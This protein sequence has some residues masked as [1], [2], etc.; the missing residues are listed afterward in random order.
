VNEGW[1]AKRYPLTYND[2]VIAGPTTDEA[3]N[4]GT[5]RCASRPPG[6]SLRYAPCLPRGRTIPGP[7]KQWILLNIAEG[8][9]WRLAPVWARPSRRRSQRRG[10]RTH[11]KAAVRLSMLRTN[12]GHCTSGTPSRYNPKMA[13]W[14]G[15]PL[16]ADGT[17]LLD[18]RSDQTLPFISYTDVAAR[19]RSFTAF[20][21]DVRPRIIA[22][23]ERR[24]QADAAYSKAKTNE[25]ARTK[26]TQEV[27]H[28][29]LHSTL[30]ALHEGRREQR[31]ELT[32][33]QTLRR[34]EHDVTVLAASCRRRGFDTTPLP[35][36]SSLCIDIGDLEHRYLHGAQSPSGSRRATTKSKDD[37][38]CRQHGVWWR[39]A[40]FGLVRSPENRG[41]K[42]AR[43]VG[44]IAPGV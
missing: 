26:A 39:G 25:R 6:R 29:L 36:Q 16:R 31:A 37:A 11:P 7:T 32:Q 14:A 28:P 41:R 12:C 4:R 30:V 22:E 1:G 23:G 15:L 17:D 24:A 10:V 40:I 19:A 20:K 38:R 44:Q 33:I 5:P 27:A 42:D 8:G 21:E 34:R 43:G 2:F 13:R 3:G 35:T 9:I 18:D